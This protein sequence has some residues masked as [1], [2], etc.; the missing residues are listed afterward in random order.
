MIIRYI[1]GQGQGDCDAG[2]IELIA[3]TILDGFNIGVFSQKICETC[4]YRI[5]SELNISIIIPLQK[6]N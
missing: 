1:E 3:E 5:S 6:K 2:R 4:S